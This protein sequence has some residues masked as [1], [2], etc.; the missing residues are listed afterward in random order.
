MADNENVTDESAEGGEKK[1][2][3]KKKIIIIAGIF[4][5][6]VAGVSFGAYTYLKGDDTSETGE[7]ITEDG[8][9]DE[10]PSEDSAKEAEKSDTSQSDGKKVEGQSV[11]E[12]ISEQNGSTKDDIGFGETFKLA[13]FSLNLA[14]LEN[15]YIRVQIS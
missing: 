4:I 8:T 9:S 6:I 1:R 5:A 3:R 11:A 10:D 7:V 12:A 14:N 2:S 15:H 13:P